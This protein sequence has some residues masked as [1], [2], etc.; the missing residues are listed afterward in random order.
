M[1]VEDGVSHVTLELIASSYINV[2]RRSTKQK[3]SRNKRD[4]ARNRPWLNLFMYADSTNCVI[5][6]SRNQVQQQQI[7]EYTAVADTRRRIRAGTVL[8]IDEVPRKPPRPVIFL[9]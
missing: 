7:P 3:Q 5:R 1:F 4:A 8:D 2:V 9:D 6:S